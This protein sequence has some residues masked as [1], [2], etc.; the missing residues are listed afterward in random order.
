MASFPRLLF[1]S[2]LCFCTLDMTEAKDTYC[3]NRFTKNEDWIYCTKFGTAQTSRVRVKLR[4]KFLARHSQS[5]DIS[6]GIYKD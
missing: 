4:S 6:V 1:L 3:R 2:L 5:P